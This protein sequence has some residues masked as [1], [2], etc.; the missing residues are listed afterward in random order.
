MMI[1]AVSTRLRCV[2]AVTAD[3]NADG[4]GVLFS[5]QNRGTENRKHVYQVR[6]HPK[7]QTKSFWVFLNL[8]RQLFSLNR[9]CFKSARQVWGEATFGLVTVQF[10]YLLCFFFY[11][12]V[13]D[14][15]IW[16]NSKSVIMASG[17]IQFPVCESTG[18]GSHWAEKHGVKWSNKKRQI[19]TTTTPRSASAG[20][21]KPPVVVQTD[22]TKVG[23]KGWREVYVRHIPSPV[24]STGAQTISPSIQS[25]SDIWKHLMQVITCCLEERKPCE[26]T[27][28]A[29][30]CKAAFATSQYLRAVG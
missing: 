8:F 17:A 18:L 14:R 3:L 29:G 12:F 7:G 22:A 21:M 25:K 10:S 9:K 24:C 4:G 1:T 5:V 15:I 20:E 6:Q 11:I 30:S 26:S 13:C 28:V 27:V 23:S 2:E 19:H 16:Q